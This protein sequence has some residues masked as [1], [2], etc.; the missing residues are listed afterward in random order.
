MSAPSPRPHPGLTGERLRW[1]LEQLVAHHGEQHWW[2]AETAFEVLV[3]AVLTQ[4][5]AWSNVER[6]MEQLRGAGLLDPVALIEAEGDEVAEAI[7][8]AGYFNVKTR[9][10]RNLCIAY[11]QEGCMEGM[12]LRRTEALREKLL[13]VNGVGRETA[14]DILLYAFHRPVFVIDAYTR[15]ILQRLGWIQGDE[16]YERLRAGVEAAL[17]PDTAAFN[18][19]HAQIVAL[20]K[21]TCR[22]TPRC[23]DCPL[24]AACAHAAG[25]AGAPSA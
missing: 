13:A 7:R 12:Q 8:P 2:P 5:T 3:G 15:R 17:G 24:S 19:L 1:L 4:N 25:G 16:G 11:L 20:G 23:A 9:R 10:L 14:D 22:P 21:D 18:E 6:A